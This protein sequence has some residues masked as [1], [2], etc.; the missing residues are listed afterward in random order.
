LIDCS[1][2]DFTTKVL[3]IDN[4]GKVLVRNIPIPGDIPVVSF[5]AAP[6]IAE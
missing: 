6:E 4:Q 5:R 3:L 2:K 1:G